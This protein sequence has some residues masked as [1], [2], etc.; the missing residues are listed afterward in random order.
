M[1]NWLRK[2]IVKY[3]NP[4]V[5]IGK[6]TRI[7]INCKIGRH[8]KIGNNNI[9]GDSEIKNFTYMGSSC[10]ISKTKIGSF[11]SLASHITIGLANH[12]LNFVS[13]YPGFYTDKTSGGYFFGTHHNFNEY[14]SVNIGSDVWIGERAILLQG[15]NIG[16][17][18]VVATGAVVTKDVEPYA[19]VGGVPAKIIKYRFNELQREKLLKSK[20]WN[21]DFKTLIEY[22][23]FM[24]NVELFIENLN[25][26]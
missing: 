14:E 24:N 19:I 20:W 7:T 21:K 26:K 5:S 25:I 1:K 23:K 18:A 22:S 17:G 4:K 11:C 15:I 13:T 10:I 6:G 3:K 9:I 16:H 2:L 12:P 8:V